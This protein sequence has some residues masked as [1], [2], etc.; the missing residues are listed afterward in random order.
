MQNLLRILEVNYIAPGAGC[1]G[2]NLTL[3][4]TAFYPCIPIYILMYIKKDI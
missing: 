1:E 4:I 2:F 3:G